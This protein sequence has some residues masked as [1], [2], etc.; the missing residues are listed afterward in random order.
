M[1]PMSVMAQSRTPPA[2]SGLAATPPVDQT[3]Q[4]Y[5]ALPSDQKRSYINQLPA[6]APAAPPAMQPAAPKN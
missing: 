1:I 2:G 6:A 5:N 3:K 4:Q